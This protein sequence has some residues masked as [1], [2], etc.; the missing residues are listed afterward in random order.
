MKNNYRSSYKRVAMRRSGVLITIFA[1]MVASIPALATEFK[2]GSEWEGTFDAALTYSTMYRVSDIDESYLTIGKGGAEALSQ[3]ASNLNTNKDDGNRNF[4]KG[5]Q[6]SN[7]LKISYD[8]EL[9]RKFS[10]GTT[11]GFFNRGLALYDNVIMNG[12]TSNDDSTKFL[13][14][15][16][17]AGEDIHDFTDGTKDRVGKDAKILDAFAYINGDVGNSPYTLRIG[18]QVISWGENAFI[19]TGISNA[20]NP[21]DISQAVLPGTAVKD[22]LLPQGAVFGSLGLTDSV[23]LEAYYQ[24][25]WQR[26]IAPATGTF[27]SANDFIAE[28]GAE[29]IVLPTNG[30]LLVPHPTY[31]RSNDLH[32]S[33][34]GQW[35]V[36]LRWFSE[37]LNETDFGFY[38]INYHSKL[39]TLGISGPPIPGATYNIAYLE[40]IR[41]Y[42]VSFNTVILDTAFS[43]EFAYHKDA[44][45]QTVRFGPAAIAKGVASDGDP[46]KTLLA[47]PSDLFVGQMTFN[48]NLI[49]NALFRKLSDAANLIVEVGAVYTPDLKDDEIF[50]GTDRVNQFAWGYKGKL[51][52]TYFDPVGRLIPAFSGTDL[53]IGLSFSHDVDG[54]SAIPAGSFTEGSKSLGVNLNASWQNT[55]EASVGANYFFD[56]ILGDRDNVSF[57]LKYLF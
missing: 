30:N 5:D 20:I 29:T 40:D 28:D 25:E 57:S 49:T 15:R 11:V 7:T 23:T 12:E 51:N 42:G 27:F 26:T 14:N 24:Y 36:A 34:S 9:K 33:D 39:P 37:D 47:T 6:V 1:V 32:P 54:I 50:R 17:Y 21:A 31:A 22:I 8:F 46:S 52:L 55:I 43:G 45:I 2:V 56:S 48:R 10:N 19:Q 44:Q 35:G 53:G 4:D 13:N 16:F 38:A 3:P 41:L 18:K